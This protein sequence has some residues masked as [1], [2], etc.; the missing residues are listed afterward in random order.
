MKCQLLVS[1]VSGLCLVTL[2]LIGCSA[3]SAQ[4]PIGAVYPSSILGKRIRMGVRASQAQLYDPGSSWVAPEAKSESLIYVSDSYTVTVYSYPL[5]KL[6]GTLKHFYRPSGECVD[7]AGD[8]FIANEDTIVEYKHGGEKPIETLT[9]PGYGSIGCAS[10][11]TTGS[12]AVT[13]DDGFSN[14]YVAIYQHASGTPTLYTNGNMLFVFCGYDDKGNLYVDGQYGEANKFAFAELPKGA[15]KLKSITLNQSFVN[16]GAVQWDGKY[17]A[18]GDDGTENAQKIYRFS[19]SGS[20]GTLEGTTNLGSSYLG[21][22][23]WIDRKRVVATN[24]YPGD[25]RLYSQVLYYNYPAGGTATKTITK[26]VGA[27]FGV[28]ISKAPQ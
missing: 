2:L 6:V 8:V 21:Y 4:P 26:D 13:W 23:W 15:S 28:T 20:R 7:S 25:T 19:I 3:N 18:V 10:D 1:R 22:Q 12:L 9:F 16:K 5:G 11:P 17:V 14:G 27:P 24:R